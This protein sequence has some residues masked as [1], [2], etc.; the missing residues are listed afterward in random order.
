MNADRNRER[1]TWGGVFLSILFLVL[2]V[3]VAIGSEVSGS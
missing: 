1:E 3:V 2:V